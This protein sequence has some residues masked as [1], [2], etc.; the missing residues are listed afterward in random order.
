VHNNKAEKKALKATL[1]TNL[2]AAKFGQVTEIMNGNRNP[3]RV[4]LLQL[5]ALAFGVL[6]AASFA[7]ESGRLDEIQGLIASDREAA[8]EQLDDFLAGD[9]DGSNAALSD[10]ATALQ[11]RTQL[12]RDRRKYDAARRDAES[13]LE[14]AQRLERPILASGAVRLL[15]TVDAEAGD[16]VA[17]LE[18]FQEAFDLLE[19]TDA[20]DERARTTIAMGMVNLFAENNEQAVEHF[21]RAGEI[22]ERAG[23]VPQQITALANLAVALSE[24]RGPEASLQVH[25]EALRLAEEVGD[26]SEQGLHR[27]NICARLVTLG[28]LDE[29]EPECRTGL[30][31]L[32]GSGADRHIAGGR[33]TLGRLLL[34]RGDPE[35][36][37]TWFER[38]RELTA[39]RVPSVELELFGMMAQAAGAL[40]EHEAAASF[41]RSQLDLYTE[42]Q[43]RDNQ[44]MLQEMEARFRLEQAEH[45]I[46]MLEL[47][48]R[49]RETS[50]NRRNL[51]LALSLVSLIVVTVF[52]VIAWRAYR[53]QKQLRRELAEQNQELESALETI[54]Q[55][56]REDSLTGLLNR[57]AFV[58]AVEKELA[59][60]RRTG[61]DA[62]LAMADIDE[63]KRIN[64]EHGHPIGDEVLVEVARRFREE[65]REMD[66]IARWG[67]EEFMFLLPDVPVDCAVE[68][69][70]RLRGA[71]E[72]RKI[73]TSAGSFPI[74]LTFGAA[75]LRGTIEATIK[76]ADA[77]MYEGKRAGRNRVVP[78][79]PDPT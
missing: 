24:T 62:S 60:V 42:L 25:R 58:A 3:G 47:Q 10:R 34:E 33:M 31:Q 57:D 29:A 19:G 72:K 78:A 69:M 17:A 65:L 39:G 1:A 6:A 23:D 4:F 75:P 9:L 45:D 70:E 32:E 79:G 14:I 68:A 26:L 18:H 11:L 63:F 13:S 67:G 46:E 61:G 73:K 71:F 66:S 43:Q 52:A 76:A 44:Q 40:G 27:I 15:G 30:D 8:L 35:Q 51:L 12:L 2:S 48:G 28:R 64:D 36:A 54:G 53:T 50:L 20:D 5:L 22:A 49:L 74:Q 59:R 55:M 41:L 56:A 77:A 7:Q 37:L 21:E 16:F 38:A